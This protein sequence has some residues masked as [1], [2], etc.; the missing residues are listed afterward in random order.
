MISGVLRNAMLF[1]FHWGQISILCCSG[2]QD[3]CSLLARVAA[4]YMVSVGA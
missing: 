3:H 4:N 1:G 2:I